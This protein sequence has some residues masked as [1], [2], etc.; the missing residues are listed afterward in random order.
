[1]G[2]HVERR[3]GK[4]NG[5]MVFVRSRVVLTNWRNATLHSRYFEQAALEAVRVAFDTQSFDL[6]PRANVE[7]LN[8]L[9]SHSIDRQDHLDDLSVDDMGQ[10]EWLGGRLLSIHAHITPT[11]NQP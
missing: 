7:W 6:H 3:Y 8:L 11:P 10:A 9:E 4:Y 2:R 1:M 5:G